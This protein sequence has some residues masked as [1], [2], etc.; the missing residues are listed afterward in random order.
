[1]KLWISILISLA[2]CVGPAQADEVEQQIG[3][4]AG[5]KVMSGTRQMIQAGIPEDAAVK[6][7]RAMIQ[8]QFREENT[9]RAQQIVLDARKKGL[10]PSPIMNKAY[11]GMAKN[12]PD[13]AIVQA[14][15]KTRSRYAYAYERSLEL[16]TRTQA[17]HQIG[18]AIAD[19][20]SAGMSQKDMDR[21]AAGLQ[22]R[23]KDQSQEQINELARETFKAVRTMARLGV[24]SINAAETVYQALQN[25][26]SAREMQQLQT[27]FQ[28]QARNRASEKL[29]LQYAAAI[30]QGT[31]AGN[32]GKNPGTG[33]GKSTGNGGE[34][35][36]GGGS[37][38]SG[39][40]SGGSGGGSGGSGGGSGGSGGG[41][42]GS[43]G[44]SGGSGGGSGGSGR[45]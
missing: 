24:S 8:H 45:K 43:G 32:L 15:E 6:M 1:M 20:L 17:K 26:Y 34:S 7:T 30:R 16:T 25:Q 29:A 40:G 31:R 22:E 13:R 36:S 28:T 12:V 19:G 44:G 2:V 35:G 41:S 10:P 39:G 37:G 33:S 3:Q 23:K 21:I 42:G 14:M 11:E 5:Q 9:L 27:Q 38:G 18:N 4:M